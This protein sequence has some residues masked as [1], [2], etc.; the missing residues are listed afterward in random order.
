[1]CIFSGPVERVANTRIFARRASNGRQVLVYQMQYASRRPVAMILPI[2]V[3]RAAASLGAA[4]LV[5]FV[6][7]KPY[8]DFFADMN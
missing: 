2:P 1:M 6:S 3:S 5:Q 8:P 7:L 4:P